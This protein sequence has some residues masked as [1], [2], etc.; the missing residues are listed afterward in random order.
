[1]AAQHNKSTAFDSLDQSIGALAGA[2]LG[3]GGMLAMGK[4]PKKNDWGVNYQ[5]NSSTWA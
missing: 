3:P 2:A 4:K 5:G 1:M